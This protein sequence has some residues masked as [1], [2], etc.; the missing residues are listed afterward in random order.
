MNIFTEE[1]PRPAGGNAGLRDDL[2]VRRWQTQTKSR[3]ISAHA[4]LCATMRLLMSRL[5]QWSVRPSGLWS[6]L[7]PSLQREYHCVSW[8]S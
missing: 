5:I 1:I 6:S 4:G 3:W 8:K 7:P 2:S